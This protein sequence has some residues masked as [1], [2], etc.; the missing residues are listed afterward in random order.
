MGEHKKYSGG[1]D[2]T[3]DWILLGVNLASHGAQVGLAL[4]RIGTNFNTLRNPDGTPANI[5]ARAKFTLFKLIG[6]LLPL[7]GT[8]AAIGVDQ[9]SRDIQTT[10]NPI[11]PTRTA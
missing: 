10:P 11:M 7:A 6:D 9:L 8:A 1:F 4:G 3:L 5:A 2:S